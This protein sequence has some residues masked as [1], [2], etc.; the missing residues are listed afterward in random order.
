[1]SR[2][3]TITPTLSHADE[4]RHPTL[5][6]PDPAGQ[7]GR[8]K[9]P[10]LEDGGCRPRVP[11]HQSGGG[12]PEPRQQPT[13]T[14]APSSEDSCICGHP[15]ERRGAQ[16]APGRSA[17][18]IHLQ[19][20]GEQ[21]V[22]GSVRAYGANALGIRPSKRGRTPRDKPLA[23]P[24]PPE[25]TAG[26]SPSLKRRWMRNARNGALHDTVPSAAS[27]PSGAARPPSPPYR[28]QTECPQK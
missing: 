26:F 13:S 10:A 23:T 12:R 24:R 6:V 8:R 4:R 27:F 9:C 20:S 5:P 2:Y 7:G 25:A 3:G 18:S 16:D 11:R 22:Q 15:L 28:S 1:M 19:H 14:R 17:S 21:T